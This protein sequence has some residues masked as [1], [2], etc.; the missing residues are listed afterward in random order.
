MN[1][2]VRRYECHLCRKSSGS[3]KEHIIRH[4]RVHS[5]NTPFECRECFKQF[6]QESHLTNHLKIH[7]GPRPFCCSKCRLRFT[8]QEE[9][10]A[11]EEMCNR[12]VFECFVCGKA[13]GWMKISLIRHMRI[14]SGEKPFECQQCLKRFQQNNGLNWHMRL[15]TKDFSFECLICR[16]G[17]SKQSQSK[18]HEKVCNRRS[19]EC[20]LCNKFFGSKKTDL[21]R[22]MLTHSGVKPFQCQLCKRK[23]TS[24]SSLNTHVKRV[25]SKNH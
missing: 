9:R 7:A 4:M 24:K 2:K 15:H 8:H 25:H 3:M 17:F 18:A 20:H 1:C 12:R 23:F 21:E 22:H 19:Y 16:K 13:F 5:G 6:K 10:N 11:H 14:H